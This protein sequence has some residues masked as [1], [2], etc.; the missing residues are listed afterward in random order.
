MDYL[1]KI[2]QFRTKDICTACNLPIF[3]FLTCALLAACLEAQCQTT[4]EWIR[5][6]KTQRKYLVKQIVL[7]Q[8]YLGHI[9]KGYQIANKGLATLHNIKNGNFNLHRDFFGSL[10]NVNASIYR[11]AKVADIIAYQVNVIKNVKRLKIYYARSE[12]FTPDEL[13]YLSKV[14]SNMLFLCDASISELLTII[15]AN[16]TQMKDDERLTRINTLYDDIID[17]HCFVNTFN[18]DVRSLAAEREREAARINKTRAL[19]NII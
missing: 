7:L 6:K 18:T 1:I 17:K 19:S 3:I 9:K 13:R 12:Q 2:I 8:T 14:T 15:R 4:N 10:Q 16:E 11:S 5:Q